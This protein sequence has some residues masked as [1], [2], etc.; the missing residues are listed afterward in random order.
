MIPLLHGETGEDGALREVLDLVGVP[1]V[2]A[3][4]AA[5]RA[6][7]DKPIAKTV[8][9]RAGLRTARSVT[10]PHETVRELERL[11]EQPIRLALA[12]AQRDHTSERDQDRCALRA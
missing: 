9:E 2:G 10:L 5:C 1:Y 8:V 11:P 7:F 12:L 6:A 3:G 4:P